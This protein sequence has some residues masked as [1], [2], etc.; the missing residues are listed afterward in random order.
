MSATLDLSVIVPSCNRSAALAHL[1]RAIEAQTLPPQRYEVI[2]VLDGST[3]DS[4]AQLRAWAQAHP[5]HTL[6]VVEQPNR[7][8]SAARTHGVSVAQSP[9]LLFLDDDIVP[10]PNCLAAHIHR[11]EQS[12]ES[13]PLVLLGDARVPT[14]QGESYYDMLTRMWWDDV[15]DQR[16]RRHPHVLYHDLISNHVSMPRDLFDAAGG[17][18]ADFAGY[19]REDYDLGHRL[20]KLGARFALEPAAEAVHRHRGHPRQVLRNMQDEGR[21]D[22]R[23]GQRHPELR[24]GLRCARPGFGVR[25][26]FAWPQLFAPLLRIGP[27]ALRVCEALG[28]WFVWR[29]L[30][31]KL[32]Y[33][34]YWRGVRRAFTGW[35]AY[36]QFLDSAPPPRTAD[37][38]ITE[39]LPR[40]LSELRLCSI[41]AVRVKDRGRTRTTIRVD[42][43]HDGP[44][45]HALADRIAADLATLPM[46][47]QAARHAPRSQAHG[48]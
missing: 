16:T 23:L 37:V 11:H 27:P 12:D 33:V 8:Q 7:G 20:L 40:D 21:N 17:F 31:G 2:V 48:S 43:L 44:L 32:R 29:R 45:A 26:I 25:L 41:D 38:D 24:R 39:G 3:D 46:A 18:A 14:R 15:Y 10:G 4:S 13:Q 5:V 30:L 6:R 19:G 35:G 28:L 36:R 34:A 42:E 1:M 9:L 22:V 47:D